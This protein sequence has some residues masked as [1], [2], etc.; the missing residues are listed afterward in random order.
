ME[1]ADLNRRSLPD[2]EKESLRDTVRR[3]ELLRT[4]RRTAPASRAAA[5]DAEIRT[6]NQRCDVIAGAQ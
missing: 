6:L 2:K 1:R 3:L 5:L 4:E